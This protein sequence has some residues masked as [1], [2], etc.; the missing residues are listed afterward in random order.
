MEPKHETAIRIAAAALIL[1]LAADGL[2]RHIPW[3]VNA[4]IWTV[5]FIAAAFFA[6]T[7]RIPL[8]PAIASLFAATGLLW[9]DSPTLAAFDIFL[10]MLFLPM[11]ALGARGVT[12]RSAGLVQLGGAL[13]VTALQAVAGFPQ[14]VFSDLRWKRVPG[15]GLRRA[16]V[17]VRGTFIAAPMLLIFGSLL[18]SADQEFA[19]LLRNFFVFELDELL[20]HFIVTGIVAAI[21]AGFLRSFA[22]SGPMPA[23]DLETPPLSLPA[24]EVN[25]ALGL[26]NVL[27]AAFVA[28]QFRYFFGNT[29]ALLSEYARRGFFELVAVVALVL[30]MLLLLEWLVVEKK[31]FRILAFVQIALVFVIAASAWRR[32]ALYRDEFGLT[33]QRLYTTAFMISVAVLLVWFAATVLTGRRNRF[34]A[35]VLATGV[36]TVVVLHAINP[37][38]LILRTNLARAAEGKRELDRRYAAQLSTDAAAV[39]AANIEQFDGNTLWEYMRRVPREGEWRTWNLSRARAA[40]VLRPYESKATPPMRPARAPGS[41]RESS[42]SRKLEISRKR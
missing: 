29:P 35:G 5:L 22:L 23:F 16:G 19:A 38:A 39:V 41:T 11:L 33:E 12:L 20:E 28:V 15:G 4:L 36:A 21:C 14:L 37:D 34:A 26:V 10:L 32:M 3:G 8:F 17:A 2:L 18:S 31:L 25:F 7:P 24:P 6:R 40:A 42:S 27:F 1:G 9:R 13:V 30:P